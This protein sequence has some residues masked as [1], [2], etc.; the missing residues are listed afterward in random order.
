MPLDI[1]APGVKE[2]ADLRQLPYSNAMYTNKKVCAKWTEE[3]ESGKLRSTKHVEPKTMSKSIT[4]SHEAHFR[5]DLYLSL[6]KR[7]YRH[8][9]GHAGAKSRKKLW[10][11]LLRLVHEDRQ[12]NEANAHAVRMKDLYPSG[13]P[14][15]EDDDEGSDGDFDSALCLT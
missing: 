11:A 15:A 8:G 1:K 10:S 5:L 6:Q 2:V 14:T 12:N 13:I 3:I 9:P 4:I 7:G